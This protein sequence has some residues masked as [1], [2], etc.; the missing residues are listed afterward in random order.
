MRKTLLKYARP[1]APSVRRAIGPTR[2]RKLCEALSLGNPHD[3]VRL[4]ACALATLRG[5]N[6]V[7]L[8]VGGHRGES[9]EEFAEHGWTVHCFE[10]NPAN[11]PFI[12]QRIRQVGGRVSVFPVAVSDTPK[13]NLTFYLSD[14][15]TGISSLH[16]FH[17][18]HRQG[19]QV[20]AVTLAGHCKVNEITH[21]DFLK[22]DVEGHDFFVLKGLDW[23]RVKPDVI[24]CEFEDGKTRALGYTF[25]DMAEFLTSHGYHVVVSEWYPR[26][27]YGISHRWR[28]YADFPCQLSEPKGWGN[29]IAVKSEDDLSR[30]RYE[31]KLVKS[32]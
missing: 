23:E 19:F 5:K 6:G 16:A 27:R 3:E 21:V 12:Q 25:E 18:T 14:E 17:D 15:S 29:L 32:S 20:D 7:M 11:H 10:P 9:F 22:I 4:V 28:R 24:V 8:D 13:S 30:L 31:M 1:L 2:F 26:E